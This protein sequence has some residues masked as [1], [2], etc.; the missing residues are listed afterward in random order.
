MTIIIFIEEFLQFYE[1]I[2]VFSFVCTNFG[3]KYFSKH[4]LLI[5]DIVT[6]Q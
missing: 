5:H 2:H 1:K 4:I 3:V 6:I